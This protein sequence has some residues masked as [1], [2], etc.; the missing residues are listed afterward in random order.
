VLQTSFDDAR[1]SPEEHV[2]EPAPIL[3]I[4]IDEQRRAGIRPDISQAAQPGGS[5]GLGLGVDRLVNR[6][7]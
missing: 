2:P 5:D 1:P 4:L 3:E 6:F 7:P